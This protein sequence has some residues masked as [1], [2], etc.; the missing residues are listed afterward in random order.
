MTVIATKNDQQ[1]LSGLLMD[2][3]SALVHDFN[4]AH[5]QTLTEASE[6]TI[7][8][9]DIVVWDTDHW[10]L[11]ANL[12]TLDGNSPL[13]FG[14]GVVV[15]FDSLGDKYSQAMTTGNV[16]VLHQG[17]VNVKAT[18]LRYGTLNATEQAAA[19]VQLGKQLIKVKDVSAKLDT[20][21]Y[22]ASV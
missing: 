2:D 14:L 15:G 9:G 20:S 1:V 18:G 4:F 22:S 8:L 7:T 17:M 12:A 19:K 3:V 10:E 21:F 11:A 6:T 5:G 13:G 16:V